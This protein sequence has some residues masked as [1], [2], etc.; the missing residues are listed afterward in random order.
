MSTIEDSGTNNGTDVSETSKTSSETNSGGARIVG[1][2]TLDQADISP[3][4]PRETKSSPTSGPI[5][6]A[7]VRLS[8]HGPIVDC[9]CHEEVKLH[10]TLVV[11]YPDGIRVGKV[12]RLPRTLAK[13]PAKLPKILRIA[14]DEDVIKISNNSTIAFDL[15]IE[16]RKLVRKFKLDMRISGSELYF[17]GGRVVIYFSSEHRVDFRDLLKSLQKSAHRRVELRQIGLRDMAGLAGGVGGC[18]QELCCSKWMIAFD[19]VS[20]RA[21]KSQCLNISSDKLTGQCGKLKCCINFESDLYDSLRV[22]L[23]QPGKWFRAKFGY[24]KARDLDVLR[25]RV[26]AVPLE[27]GFVTLERDDIVEVFKSPPKDLLEILNER[28]RNRKQRN[29]APEKTASVVS[30][31]KEAVEDRESKG[32]GAYIPE[33]KTSDAP[34]KKS[35]NRRRGKGRKPRSGSTNKKPQAAN[36]KKGPNGQNKSD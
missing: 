18:G 8:N 12:L 15:M 28:G 7:G 3:A 21:A 10:D 20:I 6:V 9:E 33:V 5:P 32:S 11:R 16:A 36:D 31:A 13:T 35:R 25:Q 27:G 29:A 14:N 4:P 24:A 22:G 30:K 1:N 26:I 19:P 17:D 34:P 23:P 2:T